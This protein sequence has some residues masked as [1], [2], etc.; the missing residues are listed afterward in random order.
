MSCRLFFFCLLAFAAR[1]C[2]GAEAS[3]S[4]FVRIPGGEFRSGNVSTGKDRVRARVDDFEMLDHPVT[5]LEYKAFVDGTGYTAPSHWEAGVI[6]PGKEHHPVIF[7]NIKDA[8]RYLRWR[9]A[10]EHRLYRLPTGAEFEYAARGGLDDRLYPWGDAEPSGNANYDADGNRRFD[11]WQD[12]LQPVGSGKPNGYGLYDMAG[13]VWQMVRDEIDPAAAAYIYRFEDTSQSDNI[14]GGSVTGGSWARGAEYLR[15]G[16]KLY[17]PM[18]NRHPDLGF[19]PVREPERADWR[20]EPRRLAATVKGRGQVFLSWALLKTDA[21]DTQF[22]I[23][24][25]DD[26]N[27]AGFRVNAAPMGGGTTF[28]DDGLQVGRRYGYYVRSV[29]GQGREG[30]RSERVGVTAAETPSPI[31]T[32]FK[33][34]YKKGE[35]VPVF[36]DLD[37]DGALDCVIRLD[38]GN[39]EMSQDSG[40]PVTLEAFA[41][42]GRSLWRKD[43]CY[44]DHCFGSANN[45]PF[46]VWD[47]DGDGKAEV[48]TRLQIGDEVYVAILDGLTGRLQCKTR[49]PA[50]VS[51]F[52]LSSTRIQL[53]IAYL[54]GVHPAVI[55][56]T[57]IYENEVLNAYDGR[58]N[59][60]WQFD[61]DGATSGSGGH[62]VEVAD[63]DGDGRQEVFDGT[64]CLRP[65]GKVRWSIYRMHPDVVSIQ[66]FLPDRP[67]L[68]VFYLIESSVHAGAYMVDAA[69][70]E[71]IWKHNR[72]DDARWDHGHSGTTTDLWDGSPGI[73]C[74]GNRTRSG[75]LVLYAA[76]GRILLEPFP[77]L[78]VV[79]WD[80]DPTRELLF[81]QGRRLGNFDGQSVVESPGVR[82]NPI[83]DSQLIMCAD[84]CG[85]FRDE[86]VVSS[87]TAEG[88]QTIS[89]VTSDEPVGK[90]YFAPS[91]TLD[92]RLWLGR[93]MGGGYKSQ[94]YQPL[95]APRPR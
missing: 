32:T 79:E 40:L 20:I 91:E 80:G 51:D 90:R 35:L 69:S 3:R 37:G 63:V 28:L 72:E 7:V 36:G 83:A 33:P 15:C 75:P 11:R 59:P 65:D 18:G 95:L 16:C 2:S 25:V 45:V 87:A 53:S 77:V 41:S 44:H 66:D 8:D 39:R 73:E 9:S 23:Y 84:L 19:R 71:V 22:N 24:R 93:N 52:V 12:Y 86:L 30:R 54:D 64:T 56:Q 62:K 55:T 34:V 42:Y 58:L 43:V 31:V 47:M 4:G 5:N 68:E 14:V 48:I 46:N 74:L 67:G 17:F 85:D 49:W 76:D 27:P 1:P 26:G 81:D 92:Y 38:N 57:G 78:S 29:D 60:L 6:P 21:I 82:P 50:M 88:L 10:R 13:N 61:S 70:G 94:Y 89:V